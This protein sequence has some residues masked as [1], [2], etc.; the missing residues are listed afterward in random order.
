MAELGLSQEWKYD[1]TVGNL[2]YLSWLKEKNY[3]TISTDGEK[4]FSKIQN[5][6]VVFE[7]KK[8]LVH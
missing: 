2:F 4:S 7:K 1:L 5:T 3:M 6:L 8:I